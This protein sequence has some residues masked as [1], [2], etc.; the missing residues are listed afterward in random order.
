MAVTLV[1]AAGAAS[2]VAYADPIGEFFANLTGNGAEARAFSDHAVDTVTPHGTTINLF[3]YWV[4]ER[5]SDDYGDPNDA[6]INNPNSGINAGHAFDFRTGSYDSYNAWHRM[7]TTGI[8][9]NEL[10]ADGYPV[11]AA[12]S[13]IDAADL[14]SL[15]YL[16]NSNDETTA[17][18]VAGKRAF[19]NVGGLLQVDSNGYYYYDSTKNFASFDEGT[20]TFS[21]YDTAA[22]RT[23]E[24]DLSSD[25]QFFPFNTAADVFNESNGQLVEKDPAIRAKST[26]L[27][28]WFGASMTTRFVQPTGGL[29]AKDEDVTYHFSGDDDVWVYIDGVLVG[30]LGGVHSK[31]DLD[32]NF[33]TGEVEVTGVDGL[34]YETTL[35]TLFS[36]AGMSTEGWTSE[37]FPD[38]SLHTLKFFYLERGSADSN[39]SLKFNLVTVP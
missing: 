3:D 11:L 22:V 36:E 28:H 2:K 38:E 32:I 17:E 7:P 1:I 29:T 30:D 26:D 16:F 5:D 34:S 39:M 9:E 8:V 18:K 4:Y 21:V 19:S 33:R 27:N 10:G 20:N 6:N 31:A 23:N 25:G 35:K 12:G 37:T 13:G 14:E 24:L 15:A